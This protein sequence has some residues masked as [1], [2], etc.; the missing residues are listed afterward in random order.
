MTTPPDRPSDAERTPAFPTSSQTTPAPSGASATG[1][2]T[3]ATAG[4]APTGSTARPPARSAGSHTPLTTDRG[5]G[6]LALLLLRLA[7][8]AV[9]VAHAVKHLQDLDGF[10]A[11]VGELGVPAA[12]TAAILTPIAELAIAFGLVFGLAVRVA[13]LGLTALFVL[14]IIAMYRDDPLFPEELP[15]FTGE[16]EVLL[17][18]CGLVFLLLGGGAW[19]LDKFFR[20]RHSRA[21]ETIN[22]S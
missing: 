12:D 8:S 10:K 20:S 16:L 22:R 4:G 2:P 1:A 6:A 17:A 9:L 18:V 7:V 19:G 5:H 21:K 14:I 13:G 15:G 11:F 3:G